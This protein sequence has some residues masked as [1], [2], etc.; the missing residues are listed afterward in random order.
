MHYSSQE[1]T[2]GR[3]HNMTKSAKSVVVARLSVI[4]ASLAVLAGCTSQPAPEAQPDS[5]VRLAAENPTVCPDLAGPSNLPDYLDFNTKFG[6]SLTFVN[7]STK[8][9]KMTVA[10]IDCYDF[11]GANNPTKYNGTVLE[12]KSTSSEQLLVARR[13]CAL[14]N[15]PVL[16][17][18]QER[19]AGWK[20]TFTEVGGAGASF[21]LPMS[22]SCNT[23]DS[24]SPTMCRS[25]A[26]KNR[27]EVTHKLAGGHL[28]RTISSCPYGD[29][30]A[31]VA[32]E[33]IL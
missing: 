24:S 31:S 33:W 16:G 4:V 21:T 5:S 19:T 17:R 8:S 27:E 11:S 30:T 20:T 22:I 10:P 13:V 1:T 15:D 3:G 6:I 26:T 7:Q 32:I 18:Y 9:W 2:Q 29:K 23:F 12:A 14:F 28:V 25:G